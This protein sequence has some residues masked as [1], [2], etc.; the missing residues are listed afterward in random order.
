MKN[1]KNKSLQQ[2][3]DDKIENLEK[4]EK[5]VGG[6]KIDPPGTPIRDFT[7]NNDLIQHPPPE[8]VFP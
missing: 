1:S 2:F 8:V 6:A 4:I 5:T 7:S 3:Q